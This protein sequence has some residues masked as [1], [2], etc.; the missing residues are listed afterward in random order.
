MVSCSFL[1]ASSLRFLLRLVLALYVRMESVSFCLM[2]LLCVRLTVF[3]IPLVAQVTA[4]HKQHRCVTASRTAKTVIQIVQKYLNLSSHFRAS[5]KGRIDRDLQLGPDSMSL[6]I[7]VGK[8]LHITVHCKSSQNLPRRQN[9]EGGRCQARALDR[10][11]STVRFEQRRVSD[12][13]KQFFLEQNG[14]KYQLA[15]S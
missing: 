15:T 13:P 11:G 6:L 3:F 4:N 7:F 12:W 2:Y 14:E 8:N 9:F 1:F 5:N 10:F